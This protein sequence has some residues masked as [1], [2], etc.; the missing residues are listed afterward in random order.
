MIKKILNAII[1]LIALCSGLLTSSLFADK[2]IYPKQMIVSLLVFVN[3][4]LMGGFLKS[5]YKTG[6]L[7]ITIFAFI[8]YLLMHSLA[9]FPLCNYL[10]LFQL[11]VFFLLYSCFYFNKPKIR[12][13]YFHDALCLVGIVQS[14]IAIPQLSKYGF[15]SGAS[16]NP[17]GLAVSLVFIFPFV[18]SNWKTIQVSWRRNIYMISLGLIMLAII[19]SGCRSCIIALVVIVG[20]I[21]SSRKFIILLAGVSATL[22]LTIYYKKD[23]SKGRFFIYQTSMQMLDSRTLIFGKG[24]S[25]FKRE[26]MFFQARAFEHETQNSNAILADNVLHPLNEYF[27]LLIEHGISGCVFVFII[28]LLF[29]KHADR[30]SPHFLFMI[31]LGIIACFSYPFRYPLTFVLLA[32][33]LATVDSPK[34][35]NLKITGSFKVVIMISAVW[36]V[37]YIFRD[38]RN[39][40][41]WKKQIT[42]CLLGKIGKTLPKYNELYVSMNDNPYFLY[43]YSMVLFQSGN[44][45]KSVNV[46]SHC[47]QYLND[48]DTELLHADI[49]RALKRYDEAVSYYNHAFRMC[50]NRFQPFYQLMN[51]YQEINKMDRARLMA[52]IITR[53]KVKI[54]SMQIDNMKQEAN[55]FLNNRP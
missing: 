36:G 7:Y 5:K 19:L 31:A 12:A 27:L 33:S 47:N 45:E 37:L 26:Y 9:F 11:I 41:L 42:L 1:L 3:L 46:L 2:I 10:F 30:S 51:L 40:Y 21:I 50:P 20:F 32:Y 48:Y 53:K 34:V 35:Y 29:F 8:L 14:I 16:D 24:H 23:S 39:N 18:Y 54:P 13:D 4:A 25:G 43:N 49:S 44:Y 17:T 38:M 15:I 55:S 22:L 52:K 6:I 28:G